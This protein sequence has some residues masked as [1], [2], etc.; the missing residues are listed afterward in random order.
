M[1]SVTHSFDQDQRFV[2]LPFA[3]ARAGVSAEVAGDGWVPPGHS[4]PHV[5]DAAGVPSLGRVVHV[6]S[7]G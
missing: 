1:S 6:S 3:R 5:L 2:E 7:G 4:I